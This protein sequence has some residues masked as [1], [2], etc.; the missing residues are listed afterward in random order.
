VIEA[1]LAGAS[2]QVDPSSPLSRLANWVRDLISTSGG[3]RD[4]QSQQEGREP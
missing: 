2:R 3:R 4:A 1:F